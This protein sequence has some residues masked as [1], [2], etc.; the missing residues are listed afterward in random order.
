[1]RRR[2]V[3]ALL[4]SL[5]LLGACTEDKPAGKEG[6]K[7]APDKAE[8]AKPDEAKKNEPGKPTDVTPPS[9]AKPTDAKPTDALAGGEPTPV[10]GSLSADGNKGKFELLST[11]DEPRQELRFSPTTGQSET[12]VLTMTMEITLDFGPGAPMPATTQKTPPIKMFNTSTIGS[13]AEGRIEQKVVF[14]RYEMGEDDSGTGAM[15]AAAMGQAFDQM[16]GFEQRMIYDTRGMIIEGDWTVPP[17]MDPQLAGSLQ[18]VNQSL[19]QAM[20]RLPQEAVGVG[21]KWKEI[22]EIDSNGLKID[23]T[24]EYTIDAI[25]GKKLSVSTDISQSPKSKK[26]AAPN[27]PGVEVD[28]LEFDSKGTGKVELELDH[29]VPLSGS[30]TMDTS[31]TVEAGE[32]DQKQ[33]VTTKI[34]M[35]MEI[36]RIDNPPVP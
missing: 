15:M 19:E 21:A 28:L 24:A 32:G 34:K 16:K 36:S 5:A 20:L 22:S 8:V 4:T 13:V 7:K 27:M 12:M 23:Q 26:I 6:D 31:L 3:P 14:D 33:K 29:M 25:D 9:D 18:N 2:L 1:M 35:T 11:G 10:T 17:G 30:S